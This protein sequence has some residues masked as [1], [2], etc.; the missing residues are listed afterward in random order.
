M[1]YVV[2][3][4]TKEIGIRMALGAQREQIAGMVLQ[5]GAVLAVSGL[6]IGLIALLGL[7]RLMQSLLYG[8]GVF[9]PV[10]IGTGVALLGGITAAACFFP[11]RRAVRVDPVVTIRSE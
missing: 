9:D 1:S 8:V 10:A 3:Q 4:R 6:A 5:D 2:S 11:A 7:G